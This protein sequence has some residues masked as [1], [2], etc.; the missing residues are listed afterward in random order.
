[1]NILLALL[2]A[3]CSWIVFSSINKLSDANGSG[4]CS[5]SSCGTSFFDG[6]VWW[7]NLF[8]AL[9]FTLYV[10]L[11]LNNRYNPYMSGRVPSQLTRALFGER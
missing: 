2:V 8:V 9:L 3:I 11:V 5:D 4:C 10:V 1:M 6:V 7:C